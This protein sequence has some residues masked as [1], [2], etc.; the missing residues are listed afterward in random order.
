MQYIELRSDVASLVAG[1]ELS[2]VNKYIRKFDLF[3]FRLTNRSYCVSYGK[4][5]L[6]AVSEPLVSSPLSDVCD[7]TF[8][9]RSRFG[10]DDQS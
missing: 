9:G 2:L 3:D 7:V 1:L 10:I 4:S 6:L 8:P 5:S